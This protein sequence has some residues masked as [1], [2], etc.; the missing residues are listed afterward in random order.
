[1]DKSEWIKFGIVSGVLMSMIAGVMVI[2]K[3]SQ[4]EF[5]ISPLVEAACFREIDKRTPLGHRGL[6]T[7]DYYEEGSTL[8]IANGALETQHSPGAWM[9]VYWTCRVH[10]KSRRVATVEF[11]G[12]GGGFRMKAAARSF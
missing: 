4:P 10:P 5:E 1:M 8:G 11:E 3:L 9:Q 2:W 12:A 6:V 7:F